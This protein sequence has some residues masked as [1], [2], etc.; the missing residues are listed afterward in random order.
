MKAIGARSA[1]IAGMYLL[2][3]LAL[4][5]VAVALG[6][7]LG[8]A[9]GRALAGVVARLLNFT[10]YSQATPA[11]VYAVLA[12]MG[13]LVPL[14]VSMGP[15]RR[16]TRTTVRA[17]LGDYGT[18]KGSFGSRNPG[19]WLGRIRFIDNTLLLALRNTFRRQAASR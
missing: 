5:S 6:L 8:I 19:G 16:S 12:L 15:I 7:P 4:G 9:A 1:Q 13:I 10:I 17:I 14:L 11:W 3:I 18:S 2:L